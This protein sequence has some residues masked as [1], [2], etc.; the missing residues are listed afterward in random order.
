MPVEPFAEI[1]VEIKSRSPFPATFVSGYSN[2]IE[3]Y[4][5]VAAAYEEGGYEVWMTPFSPEAAGI[6]VAESLKLLGQLNA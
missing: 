6:S 2:G 4:L 1:G 5:P 3:L